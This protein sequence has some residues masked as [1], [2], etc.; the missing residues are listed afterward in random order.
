MRLA[1]LFALTLLGAAPAFSADANNFVVIGVRGNWVV[2]GNNRRI[3]LDNPLDENASVQLE[4]PSAKDTTSQILTILLDGK[5]VTF[6]CGDPNTLPDHSNV[7]CVKPIPLKSAYE[8]VERGASGVA[9]IWNFV[10]SLLVSSEGRYV[11]TVGRGAEGPEDAVVSSSGYSVD[12]GPAL[13]TLSKGEYQLTFQQAGTGVTA[14]APTSFTFHWD[15]DRKQPATGLNLAPGL[16]DMQVKA[17][18]G[19]PNGEAWVLIVSASDFEAKSAAYADVVR[20]VESWGGVP[21]AGAHS[22]ERAALDHL[23]R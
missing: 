21:A 16:Y 11:P 4:N 17:A 7:G 19:E 2:T 10:Q 22:V 8:R 6:N 15:P 9:P 18:D 3:H 12:L 23:S 13:G 1:T 5:R 20:T 14:G